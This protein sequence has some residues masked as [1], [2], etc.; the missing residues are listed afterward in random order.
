MHNLVKLLFSKKCCVVLFVLTTFFLSFLPTE[1][2]FQRLGGRDVKLKFWVALII[3]S[4]FLVFL[5]SI[6]KMRC[7]RLQFCIFTSFS[8]FSIYSILQTWIRPPFFD[9]TQTLVTVF[10][11]P[12]F[13]LMGMLSA[14]NKETVI[15][16]LF[17]L[18]GFY[19]I[20]SLISIATGNL[21][22]AGTKGFQSIVPHSWYEFEHVGYKG[23]TFYVAV[24]SLILI[25]WI[26][27]KAKFIFTRVLVG[28]VGI[29]SIFLLFILG[30]RGAFLAFFLSLFF[31]I[32]VK[33]IPIMYT[34]SIKKKDFYW[35]GTLCVGVVIFLIFAIRQPEL[36]TIRRLGVLLREGD[37]SM[38]IH[39]FANSINIWLKDTSTF[40]FGSG[41]QSFP[42][43][44]GYTSSGM[45]PH[46][47]ILEL[48]CEYGLIGFG[49]FCIP[50]VV[51][52]IIYARRIF[53]GRLRM[54]L[55]ETVLVSITMLFFI[56]HMGSGSLS[57]IWPLI[58]LIFTLTPISNKVI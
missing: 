56:E 46:N 5:R 15:D 9:W 22:L 34:F 48:L 36:L 29:Y 51:I 47:F 55:S 35:V 1:I 43:A 31:L 2:I 28:V 26:W 49:L 17:C 4:L 44:A 41:P 16:T 19:I 3:I 27:F 45:Y 13:V 23:A 40:L 33:T 6:R 32:L 14:Q 21:S 20:C 30:G 38:R 25:S 7:S 11:V 8:F 42:Q 18:S 57:S 52:A 58:Y 24:F 37:H 12:L 53:S 10:L 54:Q 50:M 39:L